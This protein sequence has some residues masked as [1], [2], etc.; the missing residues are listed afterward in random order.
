MLEVRIDLIKIVSHPYWHQGLRSATT[1]GCGD[2]VDSES[3]KPSSTVCTAVDNQILSHYTTAVPFSSSPP[4]CR[5]TD[6]TANQSYCPNPFEFVQAMRGPHHGYA[7]SHMTYAP[8]LP[9]QRTNAFS[10]AQ[11]HFAIPQHNFDNHYRN[12][13][14]C[15][16]VTNEE[17]G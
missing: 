17:H 3:Q 16:Q 2:N 9:S 10:Q 5:Y 1:Y 8:M 6:A 13:N 4:M 12:V 7:Q 11:H 14:G 15:V